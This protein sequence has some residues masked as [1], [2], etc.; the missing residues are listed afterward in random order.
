MARFDNLFVATCPRCSQRIDDESFSCINCGKGRIWA[1]FPQFDGGTFLFGCNYC[2]D[3]Y[4]SVGLYCP[5]C[6]SKIPIEFVRRREMSHNFFRALGTTG[7]VVTVM[8]LAFLVLLSWAVLR[9]GI[10]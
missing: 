2:G 7:I 3:M 8:L 6:G 1:T 4:S 9:G 10:H 5:K